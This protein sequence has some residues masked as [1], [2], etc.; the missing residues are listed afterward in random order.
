MD[1]IDSEGWRF[2]AFVRLVPFFPFNALNYAL[3]V[4]RIPLWQYVLTSALAIFPGVLAYTWLGHAS[5]QAL[6]GGTHVVRN[7]LLAMAL[8]PAQRS[9]RASSSAC[10]G[11]RAR[12]SAWL[13]PAKN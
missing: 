2:V 1:G 9:C 3:G 6:A 5:R 10:E 7:V 8:S 13:S 12:T 4:T 11:R